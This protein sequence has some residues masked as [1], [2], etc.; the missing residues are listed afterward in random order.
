MREKLGK[1]IIFT[2]HLLPLKRGILSTVYFDATDAAAAERVL[3]TAYS[4]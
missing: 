4:P 1:S 2:P 3:Q